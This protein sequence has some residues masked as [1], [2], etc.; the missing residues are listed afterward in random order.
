MKKTLSLLMLSLCAA[1][2]QAF[3]SKMPSAPARESDVAARASFAFAT[4]H[5]LEVKNIQP[6]LC[7]A[8]SVNGC[9]CPLCTR[10]R[11]MG[12]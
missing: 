8:V 11:G 5:P 3:T 4:Y 1:K 6:G 9:N 2:A 12:R 10:L 7:S